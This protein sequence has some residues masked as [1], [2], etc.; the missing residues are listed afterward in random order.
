MLFAGLGDGLRD[1]FRDGLRDAFRDGLRD[2]FRDGLR[3]GLFVGGVEAVFTGM[4]T[5]SLLDSSTT[6]GAEYCVDPVSRV[7]EIY[8]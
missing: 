5:V 1:V 4:I 8:P 3:A 7:C 2:A 6:N